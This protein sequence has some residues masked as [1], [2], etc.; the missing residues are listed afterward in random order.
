MLLKMVAGNIAGCC[1]SPTSGAHGG[2]RIP[3]HPAR[4]EDPRRRD[5]VARKVLKVVCETRVLSGV[6]VNVS[7]SI[8]LSLYPWDGADS[9]TLIQKADSAMYKAKEAGRNTYRFA[10]EN[11]SSQD[12]LAFKH[13]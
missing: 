9:R 4:G 11:L 10:G 8:G 12:E 7:T 5:R 6:R 3:H 2:R 1:A 13:P